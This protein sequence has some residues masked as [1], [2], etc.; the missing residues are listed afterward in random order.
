MRTRAAALALGAL[1]LAGCGGDDAPQPAT[2]GPESIAVTETDFELDPSEARV[3]S[4]NGVS[5]EVTNAGRT[6][7]ALAIR[8]G[9]EVQSTETIE[10]GRTAALQVD[11]EP[12]RYTWYCPVGDHR[13]RGMSGTLTVGGAA[14]ETEPSA[15]A[16]PAGGY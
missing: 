6:V 1:V 4:G 3:T 7:H 13:R 12:G 16:A 5:I 11:L 9:N 15:P 8:T 2:P 10:P 14:D